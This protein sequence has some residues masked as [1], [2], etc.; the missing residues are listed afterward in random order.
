MKTTVSLNR[1]QLSDST[2]LAIPRKHTC[3][4]AIQTSWPINV[5]NMPLKLKTPKQL[6][7]PEVKKI[8]TK[9]MPNLGDQQ[10]LLIEVESVTSST[11]LERAPLRQRMR[12]VLVEAWQSLI[13][14]FYM[15]GENLTYVLFV[16]L[17][18]WCLYLIISHYYSFLGTNVEGHHRLKHPLAA[19]RAHPR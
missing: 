5:P 17:C 10:T 6:P 11:A 2:I 18:L 1:M 3:E 7:Q 12:H 16:M 9:S 14:C 13:A 19:G 4:V 15:M 8:T